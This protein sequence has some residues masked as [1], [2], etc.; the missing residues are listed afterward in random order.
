MYR[1]HTKLGNRNCNRFRDWYQAV[2]ISF[3]FS[4]QMQVYYLRTVLEHLNY[5][6]ETRYST[7]IARINIQFD[8]ETGLIHLGIELYVSAKSVQPFSI[9]HRANL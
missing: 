7:R 9:I 4:F 3:E 2:P 1:S 6:K 8:R 5:I